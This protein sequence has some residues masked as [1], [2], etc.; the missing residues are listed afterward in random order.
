MVTVLHEK[1]SF[2]ETNP[3][4][5]PAPCVPLTPYTCP[6]TK[7]CCAGWTG[8]TSRWR[9]WLPKGEQRCWGGCPWVSETGLGV[10]CGPTGNLLLPRDRGVS[11]GVKVFRQLNN[12]PHFQQLKWPYL[13]VAQSSSVWRRTTP[14]RL[15][16]LRNRNGCTLC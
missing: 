14:D 4:L 7:P 11:N 3:M 15:L 9:I 6:R 2:S 13:K 1:V 12:S 8:S 5:Q 16:A 10:R